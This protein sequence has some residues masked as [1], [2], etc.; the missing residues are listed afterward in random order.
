MGVYSM[1]Q[2]IISGGQ[3]GAD[4]GGLYAGRELGFSTG[5]YAPKGWKTEAGPAQ[6]LA[7]YGLEEMPTDYYKDRI[8][9]NIE[10]SDGTVIVGIRSQGSNL[11]EEICR[12][13]GKP[14]A[15]VMWTLQDNTRAVDS[16]MSDPNGTYILGPPSYKAFALWAARKKISILNV[17]GN[18]ESK[19]P[20]VGE[21]TK[22]FLIRA[23]K[24]K[25]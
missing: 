11:A 4:Q 5:G 12:L 2:A 14:C 6:W 17:A 10:I 7:D 25:V 8:I 3:T 18:R 24:V 15:W 9:K 23:L 20:G 21:F 1:I 22:S 16:I 19:N 13:Q